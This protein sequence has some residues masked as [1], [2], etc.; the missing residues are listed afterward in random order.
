[1]PGAWSASTGR[2]HASTGAPRPAPCPP[3]GRPPARGCACAPP[4]P[5]S[6]RRFE[7]ANERL[8][9]PYGGAMGQSRGTGTCPWGAGPT[10]PGCLKSGRRARKRLSQSEKVPGWWGCGCSAWNFWVTSTGG[11]EGGRRW[12]RKAV[13]GGRLASSAA[14]SASPS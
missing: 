11:G 6:P 1:M 4:P 7:Y 3:A 10:Y 8:L 12:R 2:V 13:V 14:L 5:A 9:G